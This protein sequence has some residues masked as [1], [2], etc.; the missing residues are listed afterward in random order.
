M[1]HL[2]TALGST[3]SD[4]VDRWDAQQSVYVEG[5]ERGY[6]VMLSVLDSLLPG[7]ITV[8]DLAAGPGSLSKRLLEHRANARSVAVDLDPVLQALGRNALGDMGGRLHWVKADLRDVGWTEQLQEYDVD[9]V[10]SSTATHWLKPAE[11]ANLYQSLAAVMRPGGVFLNFD[12][13][14]PRNAASRF[15]AVAKDIHGTRQERALANGAE[16]WQ[17]WWD[18]VRALPSLSAEFEERD[19][20]FAPARGRIFSGSDHKNGTS[21]EYHES[22]LFEA[23]FAEVDVIWQDLQKK[24]VMAVR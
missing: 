5:R 13:F 7:A 15:S 24:I 21:F 11:L 23:G 2:D 20:V 4:L 1:M 22:S 16:A 12:G 9:A 19:R 17:D 6:G 14:P 3:W 18:A 8:L 10:L